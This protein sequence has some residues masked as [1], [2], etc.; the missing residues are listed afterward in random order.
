MKCMNA[1]LESPSPPPPLDQGGW[2]MREAKASSF[3]TRYGYH[4]LDR[5]LKIVFKSGYSEIR[6]D[7]SPGVFSAMMAAQSL[8]TFF[9]AYIKNQFDVV[10]KTEAPTK[11]APELPEPRRTDART[12]ATVV[13]LFPGASS[14]AELEPA[15][16]P[17]KEEKELESTALTLAE[18]A[19]QIKIADQRTYDQAA[20]TFELVLAMEREITGHYKPLKDAA[21]Q[22]HKLIC[23]AEK[24]ML[25]P[26]MAAKRTL[27]LGM[28][29]YDSQQQRERQAEE[30]RLQLLH[31]QEAKAV[32][33][34]DAIEAETAGATKEEVAHIL[35][36]PPPVQRAVAQPTYTKKFATS[37]LWR[38]YPAVETGVP[39]NELQQLKLI[40]VAAAK[41][42]EAFLPCL[43]LNLSE[44]NRRA[45]DQKGAFN[46]PGFIAQPIPRATGNRRK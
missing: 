35:Q 30:N 42:P 12:S 38:A 18:R 27:S 43:S 37:D 23:S 29:Q 25:E 20:D 21:F 2:D 39:L 28:G 19:N 36:A 11:I 46:V 33:L 7:V 45:K 31:E 13:E 24:K 22:S 44:I 41:N 14:I 15:A 9:H 34:E 10:S 4:H 1:I 3:I 17:A 8:G 16:P 40:V 26:V 6:G 32:A 5:Q